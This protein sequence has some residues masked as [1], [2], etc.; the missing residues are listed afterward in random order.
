MTHTDSEPNHPHSEQ[1]MVVAASLTKSM[2]LATLHVLYWLQ[3]LLVKHSDVVLLLMP[4][5][6][7]LRY[8]LH[9]KRC[10]ISSNGT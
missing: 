4:H 10:A 7:L 5:V 8:V 3:S 2:L 1:G 6:H 9:P